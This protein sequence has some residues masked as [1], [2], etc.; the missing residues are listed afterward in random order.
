MNTNEQTYEEI[1]RK[2]IG[3][4]LNTTSLGIGFRKAGKV[5]DTYRVELESGEAV[6]LVTTDRVSA[7]DRNI[8]VIPYKGQVLNLVSKWWFE[9]TQHLV[10]NHLVSCPDPNTVV[11]KSCTVFSVEFVVRSYLTGSTA[12]SIWTHYNKGARE[13]CGHKLPEG[14]KKNQKLAENIVTPTTKDD[15]HDE[16]ITAEEIV[17]SGRM[18]KEEW[19]YCHDAALKLFAFGQEIA[20]K[21]GLLLVDTKYEFGKDKEGNIL[22]IDEI[23][24]PDSSRYW[25]ADSYASR[26]E[27]GEEPLSVDKDILRRWYNENSNPYKDEVL[28][29]APDHLVVSLSERY[30]ELYERITGEKFDFHAAGTSGGPTAQAQMDPLTALHAHITRHDL[31]VSNLRTAGL[32]PSPTKKA[33]ILMGSDVDA[34]WANAI[35]KFLEKHG[36]SFEIHQGSAHK[37]PL[38]VLSVLNRFEAE[39]KSHGG[40]VVY[41][42]I[43][44]RSN[45]LSG[46][47]AANTSF[48]TLACPPFKDKLDM[49]VNINSTLQ[50]PSDVPALTVLEP[51]NCALAVKRIFD[52]IPQ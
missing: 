9:K 19:Q 45:A 3:N 50:M 37:S 27:K 20:K 16:L 7:F 23:H 33:V 48:P 29:K 49:M 2:Q 46:F 52:L 4:T 24:T 28:P 5:R 6:I 40:V 12:T 15:V 39:K 13:Y 41:I 47:V 35:V 26:F 51:S 14:L 43:A 42:T 18:T 17:R 10:P 22:L 38:K 31:L 8:A 34:P 11:C 32:I 25:L 44:G 1:I 30:I 21:N 36:L